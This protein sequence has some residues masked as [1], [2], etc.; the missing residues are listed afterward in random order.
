MNW[1]I[2]VARG[3]ESKRDSLSSGER[4]GNSLNR[5]MF[6]IAGSWEKGERKFNSIE[7]ILDKVDDYYTI[8]GESPVIEKM[9]H[10]SF[11]PE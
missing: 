7:V 1:N 8:E 4:N 2:L 10:E 9:I 6:H 11:H 3:E 5:H